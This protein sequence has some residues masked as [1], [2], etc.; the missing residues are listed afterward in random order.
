MGKTGAEEGKAKFSPTTYM[1][2]QG[3]GG[4][5]RRTV[6]TSRRA[7]KNKR[8]KIRKKKSCNLLKSP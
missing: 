5:G 7:K 6:L 4:S 8:A 2:K 1:R 3:L